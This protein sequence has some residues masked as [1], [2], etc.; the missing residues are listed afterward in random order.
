MSQAYE[1]LKVWQLGMSLAERVYAVTV[2]FPADERFGLTAQLRR[3][4]VSIP[5]NIAEGRGRGYDTEFVRFLGVAYGSLMETETQVKLAL[6]IGLIDQE[7]TD[8]IL[9]LCDELGRMLN[10][11]MNSLRAPRSAAGR[12]QRTADPRSAADSR[13]QTADQKPAADRRPQTAD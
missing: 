9:N 10:G 13:P 7:T 11:L 1:D 3:A 12:R 8:E 4:A 5:S 6:R 2:C